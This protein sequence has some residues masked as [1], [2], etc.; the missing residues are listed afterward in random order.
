[1]LFISRASKRYQHIILCSHHVQIVGPVI[2][3]GAAHP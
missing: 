1:M 2:P 3:F